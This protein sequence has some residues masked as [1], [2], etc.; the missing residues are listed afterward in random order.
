MY[1][2]FRYMKIGDLQIAKPVFLAPMAGITDS[3][4]RQLARE[5]GA[6]LVYT[7]LISAEGLVHGGA[8][9][10]RL[11]DFEQKERPIGVQLF[12]SRPEALARAAQLATEKRPDLIDLNF[13]CPSRKVVGK[14]GGAALLKDLTLIE[15]IVRAVVLATDLPVTVKIRSGWDENSIVAPEVAALCASYGVAAVAVHARTRQQGFSGR[16][17]W[18][19]IRQVKQSVEIPV[20]GNG[21]VRTPQDG[22]RMFR[23]TGCDAIMVGRGALGNLWL[24]EGIADLLEGR[25]LAPGPSVDERIALCLRHAR[26]LVAKKGKFSGVRQ[27]RKHYGWYTK[28][29]PEGARLRGSLVT[30]ESLGE[31][32]ETFREYQRT[33][34]RGPLVAPWLSKM[35]D[36]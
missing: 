31:V 21:D 4:F 27:M 3:V 15:K 2:I 11:M 13:G 28:G 6:G 36:E 16:A 7:E 10:F 1:R 23:E 30:L 18:D 9:T 35:L 22:R 5:H 8:K 19:V 20:I 17:D 33:E 24:F 12:G 32:E 25:A 26:E 34:D 14:N 29:F